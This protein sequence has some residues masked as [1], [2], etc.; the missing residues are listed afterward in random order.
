MEGGREGGARGGEGQAYIYAH[1]VGAASQS[2]AS[3]DCELHTYT[4]RTHTHTHVQEAET[5]ETESKHDSTK[6][7]TQQSE[8]SQ[9]VRTLA[10]T[11]TDINCF[12]K[13]FV[14]SCISMNT[15]LEFS[16]SMCYNFQFMISWI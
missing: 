7:P 14:M 4:M 9:Q 8:T 10:T 5:F 13:D 16:I 1:S 6:H 2:P 15:K 12:C 3:T 11:C